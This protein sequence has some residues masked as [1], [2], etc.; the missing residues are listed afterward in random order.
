MRGKVYHVGVLNCIQAPPKTEC[1][2]TLKLF[3]KRLRFEGKGGVVSVSMDCAYGE[4]L[5]KI[6]D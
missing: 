4:L 6:K 2:G 3:E 5:S 1:D